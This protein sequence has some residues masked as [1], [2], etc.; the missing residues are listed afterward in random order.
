[1]ISTT[2]EFQNYDK[3]DLIQLCEELGAECPKSM[4]VR[5]N[6]LLQGS[7]VLDAF[8]RRTNQPIEET[9]KSKKARERG[10]KIIPFERLNVFF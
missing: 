8:K 7:H 2:G 3:D 9:D 6:L 4:V 10:I 5:C 1:M